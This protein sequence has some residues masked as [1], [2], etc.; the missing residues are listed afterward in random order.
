MRHDNLYISSSPQVSGLPPPHRRA[1]GLGISGC[2][3]RKD[4]VLERG[5][6]EVPEGR[7][8]IGVLI[9][10]FTLQSGILYGL[11]LPHFPS[12]VSWKQMVWRKIIPTAPFRPAPPPSSLLCKGLLALQCA[13]DGIACREKRWTYLRSGYMYAQPYGCWR[14]SYPTKGNFKSCSSWDV[15]IVGFL[16]QFCCEKLPLCFHGYLTL[17]L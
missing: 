2:G 12:P 8:G 14:W 7:E 9:I 17:Q 13:G 3:V 4:A 15:E 16:Q 11:I 5:G 10:C 1:G 6:S